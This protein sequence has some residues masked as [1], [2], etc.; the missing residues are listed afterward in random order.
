MNEGAGKSP[1]NP[2]HAPLARPQLAFRPGPA[3]AVTP[4]RVFAAHPPNEGAAGIRLLLQLSKATPAIPTLLVYCTPTL[5]AP[6]L[7]LQRDP[8]GQRPVV[9]TRPI[10][11]SPASP[12]RLCP[13][14][15]AAPPIQHRSL[16]SLFGISTRRSLAF[17][18]SFF[19]FFLTILG[20][21]QQ[22]LAARLRCR[23]SLAPPGA[24]LLRPATALQL[25]CDQRS[26]PHLAGVPSNPA[27]PH[28]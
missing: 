14:S 26:G 1:A 8:A 13:S 5:P 22:P 6:Q 19:C 21:C 2:K 10:H 9:F 11:P 3:S 23:R 24:C 27:T 7:G 4:S 15:C 16:N 17:S 18:V 20:F 12:P 25:P 28:A